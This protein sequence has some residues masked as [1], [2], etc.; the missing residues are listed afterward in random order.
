MKELQELAERLENKKLVGLR[1]TLFGFAFGGLFRILDTHVLPAS[2]SNTLLV[3]QIVGGL[4][5]LVGLIQL[6]LIAFKVRNDA[7]LKQ[8]FND[9]LSA[10]TKMK[11]WRAGFI[12]VLITQ[13]IL[14]ALTSVHQYGSLMA[15]EIT[16]YVAFCA[17]VGAGLIEE[18]LLAINFFYPDFDEQKYEVWNWRKLMFFHWLI[19]P[20]VVVSELI[21]G[22][23][24]PKVIL[25]DKQSD[26][27][28]MERSYVPC[29]HCKTLHNNATWSHKNNN[30]LGNWFGLYCYSCGEVIPCLLNIC[31]RVILVVTYPLWFW[32]KEVARAKWIEKQKQKS[33]QLDTAIMVHK[34]VP[35]LKM[36]FLFGATMFVVMTIYFKTVQY[37]SD[38]QGETVL[39][40]LWDVPFLLVSLG[41]WT[42]GGLAFGY[43]MKYMMG[44]VNKKNASKSES[45]VV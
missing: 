30:V 34:D 38:P 41:L 18:E 14:I 23:R 26:K 21:M 22:Q 12:A 33:I 43:G 5:F 31:S 28:F 1:L 42:L 2:G 16:I 20:G 10:Q 29:P 8:L 24:V 4:I 25:I 15:A 44:R 27:P 19:N 39:E 32:R 11:T 9:E 40:H 37:H 35:W 45:E 13:M 3:L 6:V 7:L 17:S 36:S